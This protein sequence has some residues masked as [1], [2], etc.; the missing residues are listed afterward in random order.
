M[1]KY[2]HARKTYF[3]QCIQFDGKNSAEVIA[4]LENH[5]SEASDYL[6]EL[7]IRWRISERYRPDI[8][9]LKRGDWVRIGENS[10][11]KIMSDAEF[12]MKYV[13]IRNPA[14]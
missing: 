7:I 11:A 9:I 4:L 13:Q 2:T 3:A 14:L 1:N 10:V 8:M 5:G 12:K 6:E